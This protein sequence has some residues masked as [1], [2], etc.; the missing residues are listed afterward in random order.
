MT[1]KPLFGLV[2]LLI[3]VPAS[4]PAQENP[5]RPLVNA[6]GY[7]VRDGG[8]WSAENAGF[9]A[10]RNPWKTFGY[11]FSWVFDSSAVRLIIDGHRANG[12]RDVFWE[13]L[14]VWNPVRRVIEVTQIGRG[15][16]LLRGQLTFLE[17]GREEI[18]LSGARG[19][20]TWLEFK[21]VSTRIDDSSFRTVAL[22][23]REGRW[24]PRPG[25]LWRRVPAA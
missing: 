24:V 6:M 4:L 17:D 5:D 12:R 9:D 23:L 14:A 25:M 16:T 15:G 7:L 1:R 22:D 13:L 21:D 18:H 10:E 20:G 3:A 11:Q 19:D 8:R 2:A